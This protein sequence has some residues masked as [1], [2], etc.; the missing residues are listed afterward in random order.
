MSNGDV[1]TPAASRP[2]P[3]DLR[4]SDSDREKVAEVLRGAL[5]DGRLDLDELSDRL[6]RVY[7]A[8]TYR[9]LEPIVSD[10]PSAGGS[11]LPA[12]QPG[13]AP[14]PRAGAQSSALDRVGGAPSSTNAVA[15]MGGTTRKG[16]WV[17]PS[18]FSALAVMGGVELDLREARFET[19]SVTINAV[20]FWGG[21]DITVGPDIRVLVDGVGVMGAFD[22]PRDAVDDS[23]VSVRVTGL[24]LMGG[25][26]VKRKEATGNA[27]GSARLE[28]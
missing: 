7:A 5:A 8:R 3:R 15:I 23:G 10:L 18:S 19:R 4:C 22:G 14:L 17:V 11:P 21:I 2:D 12:V 25:V 24:A 28:P 13:A 6:D 20:A 9:D 27:S 1:A 16:A 26:D